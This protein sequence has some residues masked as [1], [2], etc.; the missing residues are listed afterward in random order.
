MKFRVSPEIIASLPNS[1]GVY[2]FY[3]PQEELLYVGKSK[4]VRTRVRSHFSAA[5]ERWLCRKVHRV[6]VH[7]TAGELGALL[8]ES[9][10]IKEL[11]PF[12]NIAQRS[13][14][15][16]I[17][18]R[19][20]LNKQGYI[21]VNL[22]AVDYLEV[23]ESE[24]ILGVFKHRTQAK[25][26]L[27]MIAK[28]HRLCPKLLKL[29]VTKG[30]CFSYHLHQCDG[31]CM[32]EEDV[33]KYNARVEEAFEARRIKAWPYESAVAIEERVSDGSHREVFLLD[34]WCL[35]GGVRSSDGT[36]EKSVQ[37]PRRFD[38]DSY[39]ILYSYMA[40]PQNQ[41]S[42]TP[43]TRQQFADFQRVGLR[44]FAAQTSASSISTRKR[45]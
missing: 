1:P 10:L 4:T 6:E 44:S 12:H 22:D 7:R 26:F 32:G 41:K 34:N 17:V 9:Q 36:F 20:V 5:E 11:R 38:Y 40:D 42:I 23:R 21:V 2:L 19:R 8:L 13:R 29:E 24:P 33:A 16:I 27:D 39:K 37:T 3:G 30:Y 35:I 45:S 43:L 15:R 25:E 31:A 14:R 18:A 28:S